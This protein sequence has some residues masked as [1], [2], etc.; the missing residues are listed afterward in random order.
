MKYIA[1]EYYG[2]KRAMD[3]FCMLGVFGSLRPR[4]PAYANA[5]P[6]A[7]V[8]REEDALWCRA[9]RDNQVDHDWD[10]KEGQVLHFGA[11]PSRRLAAYAASI[12]HVSMPQFLVFGVCKDD[13]AAETD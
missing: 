13:G 12:Q 6:D 3:Y 11:S 5:G 10:G 4:W 1:L 7:M 2:I 8:V 9:K